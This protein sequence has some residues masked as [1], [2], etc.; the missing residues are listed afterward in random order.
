MVMIGSE[1]MEE[2]WRETTSDGALL[3]GGHNW[4]RASHSRGD[5]KMIAYG[6]CDSEA[7]SQRQA[8]SFIRSDG[9]LSSPDPVPETSMAEA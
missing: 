5:C 3:C 7:E 8:R 9:R 1:K 2:T 4:W 6:S